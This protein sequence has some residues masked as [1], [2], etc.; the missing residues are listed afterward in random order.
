MTGNISKLVTVEPTIELERAHD[1]RGLGGLIA[2]AEQGEQPLPLRSVKVRAAI[3]GDCCR[4]VIEQ[5]FYNALKQPMEAIH[6]FPLPEEGAVVEMV[7]KAGD[8][9][10]SA[11]CRERGQAEKAF[12]EARQAGHRAG[13]LTQERADVHSLRVTNL[14]PESDVIV[15]IVVVER[16][17][18]VDGLFRWRFPTAIAPR[19]L[20]GSPIGHEGPGVLPDTD[21]AP[22]ASRL[23]P[24][25]RLEGGTTLDLE[26]GIRGLIQV[27]ESSLHAIRLDLAAKDGDGVRVAPAGNTT[28][29][30]DFVLAFSTAEKEKPALRAWSDGSYTLAV[31]EPPSIALP[32]ALPRD[33]VFVVDVSGSMGGAKIEAARRALSSA[34][35]GLQEGD[36]FK[37]IA[38]NNSTTAFA[39]GFTEYTQKDVEQAD[40]WIG[41]LRASGGTEML[42]AIKE[43]LSGET[44]DGRT[45][46]MLFITDGQAW[47]ENELV[48]AVHHRRGD[49]R[50]FTMGIDVAVN[51]S[52][53]KRLARAGGGTCELLT[54][55]EDMETAVARLE[56][57]FGSPIVDGIEIRGGQLADARPRTLFSGRPISALLEGSPKEIRLTGRSIDGEV[58][59]RAR[60][61]KIEFPLGSLWARECIAA[62]EDRLT[63]RPFEEEALRPE[64]LRIALEHKIASRFTAFVAVDTSV[65]VDGERVEIVQPVELPQDWDPA[66]RESKSIDM[67]L[68]SSAGVVMASPSAFRADVPKSQRVPLSKVRYKE[69][70]RGDERIAF[71][72]TPSEAD[73]AGEIART[74]EANGSFGG[75]VLRTAAALIA[76]VFL[77]H[78]RRKG[79]RRRTV[80]KAATWLE[81]YRTEAWAALALDVLQR[82]ESGERPME[83]ISAMASKLRELTKAEPEGMLLAQLMK[84]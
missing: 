61:R 54:P 33:A 7:L 29:N 6:I 41:D 20:P 79:L 37:L 32:Q 70:S 84:P 13:L 62:L 8:V 21:H 34:L 59:M 51:S 44:A 11:E 72:H 40:R 39:E 76:L 15:S 48:A 30:K 63:L 49:V 57:R 25:L 58:A 55:Y 26:V 18:S 81:G 31:V 17:E 1:E 78:T 47:N 46:T 52:L 74:Q 22:D 64:I 23:Q 12:E 14:P 75:D 24:P 16:L 68:M 71:Q 69:I 38:F 82:A 66:F 35:H 10:V 19:Y 9:T 36:R 67:C 83:F 3:A 65:T 60:P 56:A 73:P 4:T 27:L 42:P 53:L 5:H 80:Q 50:F 2:L 28:L 43:A 45:C 77:G